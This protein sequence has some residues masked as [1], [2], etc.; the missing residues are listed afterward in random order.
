MTFINTEGLTILGQGSEWLWTL[1]QS[2][3][4]AITGF[5]IFR[6]LRAQRSA[7]RLGALFALTAE[8]DSERLARH[9]LAVLMHHAESKPGWPPALAAVG[10]FFERMA[11]LEQHGDIRL[12]DLWESWS[13]AVQLWWLRD[14]ASIREDRTKIGPMLWGGWERL[15]RDMSHLDRRRGV[16]PDDAARGYA[17]SVMI[18][19]LI[20]RLRLEQEAKAG[21]IPTW[22]REQA[23]EE[24]RA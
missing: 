3:A 1:A 15:A 24:T 5:A 19:D 22:P 21:V 12:E 18:A 2:L 20:E 8:W 7:N 9:R 11:Q 13:S 4:L 17:L 16:V 14:E 6:Q 23:V 10:S